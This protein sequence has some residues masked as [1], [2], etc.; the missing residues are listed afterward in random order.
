MNAGERSEDSIV[1]LS[2]RI[3]GKREAG[4]K[5][6]FYDVSNGSDHIQIMSA[7]NDWT[8]SNSNDGNDGNDWSLHRMLRRNDVIGISGYAGRSKTGEPTIFARTVT[9]LAP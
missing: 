3:V 4:S 8:N 7:K 5:L 2:G 9:L 6:V 1:S